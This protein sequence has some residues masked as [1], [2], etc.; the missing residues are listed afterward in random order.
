MTSTYTTLTHPI[1]QNT[2]QTNSINF[3][4]TTRC[5]MI[6]PK[7]SIDVPGIKNRKEA[8]DASISTIHWTASVLTARGTFQRVHITGG[9]P[10]IHHAFGLM[11][12]EFKDWFKAEYLTL[13]TNGALVLKHIEVIK[14]HFDLVF[15]TH[16]VKGAIY[17]D[18]FDN[19]EII[20]RA[21]QELGDKLIT[22][23]PVRHDLEHIKLSLRTED[24]KRAEHV[25]C[26]KFY[27]PGL[28]CAWYDGYLY[29]CCVSFGIDRDR[30]KVPVT[31]DWRTVIQDQN[32]GCSNCLYRGT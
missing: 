22:E 27:E 26:S 5:T 4:I 3:G 31:E 17:P 16:Y 15:I 21:K 11:T 18:N 9:E 8:Q 24:Q 12:P 29:P 1:L 13:E 7:C 25:A 30:Y 32:K 10:T 28:P 20:K 19:T 23:P 6:C 14:K 2:L